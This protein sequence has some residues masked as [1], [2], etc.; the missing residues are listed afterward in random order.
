[1]LIGTHHGK[2]H[3]DEVFAI[4]ILRQ[5]DDDT[6]IIRS[7]DPHVL[8]RCDIVVDVNRSRYDHHSTDKE[9]RENGVPFASAGLVWRDFGEE[10]VA[11]YGAQAAQLTD[12]V[13]SIDERVIQA[14][15]AIDN[16]MDLERDARIK[17]IS[18]LIGTFNPPWDSDADE[19]TQFAKAV[20]FAM[21]I[22]SNYIRSE[23]SRFGGVQ[24]V[25]DAYVS[26]TNQQ[27]LVLSQYCPWTDTLLEIDETGQVL[28]VV[29]P[30]RTGQYRLQVVPK[31]FGTFEAR[32]PLPET[33]AGLEGAELSSIVGRDDVVFCHPARFIAGAKSLDTILHMADLALRA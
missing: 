4:A 8:S 9:Y 16:G 25:R 28:F 11:R 5:L 23:I 29:F 17:G 24:I 15:D 10:V 30:D 20:E 13:K 18:E 6:K 2:F 19:D 7:R 3:A 27:L 31:A 33:W 32:K 22:L 26:R 14:I 12:I 21:Q 1:M